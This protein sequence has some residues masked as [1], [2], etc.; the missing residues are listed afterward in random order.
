MKIVSSNEVEL[1]DMNISDAGLLKLSDEKLFSLNLEEMVAIQ[2]YYRREDIQ[3]FRRNN[4]V[5]SIPTDCELE[6]IAQTLSE[7]CKHKE[8]N[9]VIEFENKEN[10]NKKKID[11][12]FKTYITSATVQ[13]KSQLEANDN[14]W[15]IKVF[16]DNAGVV[17]DNA[18]DKNPRGTR[19]FGPVAREL[20]EKGYTKIVSL[21]PEVL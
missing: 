20:R 21:A 11:S 1:I 3:A 18:K 17:I 13:V 16:S 15:L 7:H 12:L 19:I 6:I 4:G 5:S 9:A 10:G 14:H 8:F 2:S